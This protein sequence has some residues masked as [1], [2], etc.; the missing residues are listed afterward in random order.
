MP[1]SC[2][3]INHLKLFVLL[4][5]LANLFNFELVGKFWQ[6]CIL[7]VISW[8]CVSMKWLCQSS[9]LYTNIT[10]RTLSLDCSRL[11]VL[12][13]QDYEFRLIDACVHTKLSYNKTVIVFPEF[14]LPLWYI[15]FGPCL[16]CP[17]V[18]VVNST[19]TLIG[20]LCPSTGA[21]VVDSA[22]P[23]LG[24]RLSIP[25]IPT[26]SK[27]PVLGHKSLNR[28]TSAAT[29]VGA[30]GGAL[31]AF[32][33]PPVA[34]PPTLSTPATPTTSINPLTGSNETDEH[35]VHLGFSWSCLDSLSCSL[36]G[37][38][39]SFGLDSLSI[40]NLCHNCHNSVPRQCVEFC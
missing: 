21:N 4:F 2:R 23:P 31:S 39:P 33:Y 34:S 40:S 35:K 26:G 5:Y 10:D 20:W 32:A 37:G 29:A 8:W 6:E 38:R 19:L 12:L 25:N 27:L 15:G 24:R 17:V 1:I 28:A 30:T 11:L 36:V 14:D 13:I 7:R 18:G 22:T 16:Q 9:V 3:I